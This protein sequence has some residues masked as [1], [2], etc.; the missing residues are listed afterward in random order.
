MKR[1]ILVTSLIGL[2]AVLTCTVPAHQSAPRLDPQ[3]L[4]DWAIRQVD[5]AFGQASCASAD[6][7]QQWLAARRELIDGHIRSMV[8]TIETFRRQVPRTDPRM[9]YEVGP[10]LLALEEAET[11]FTQLVETLPALSL[12]WVASL[13]GCASYLEALEASL[14]AVSAG[15]PAADPPAFLRR[16]Q[17]LVD[18]YDQWAEQTRPLVEELNQGAFSL[19]KG[20]FRE[21]L[22]DQARGEMVA[23][24]PS[25]LAESCVEAAETDRWAGEPSRRTALHRRLDAWVET[26]GLTE[27]LSLSPAC[28]D[29]LVAVLDSFRRCEQALGL[30]QN[31]ALFEPMV[32][33]HVQAVEQGVAGYREGCLER[34]GPW[35]RPLPGVG[36]VSSP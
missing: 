22:F 20:R 8:E 28:R 16:Y 11:R 5:L 33:Q 15:E 9:T 23:V 31:D 21:E 18:R 34:V 17:A 30:H 26:A 19:L 32:G 14:E 27:G 7:G 1:V 29:Q 35:E 10:I 4:M 6:A 2:S 36:P 25:L 13:D 3:L 12:W 24:W